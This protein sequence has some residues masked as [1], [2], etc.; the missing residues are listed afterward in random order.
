LDKPAITAYIATTPASLLR[1]VFV[2]GTPNEVVDQ[3][4][5]WRDHGLRYLVV[6]DRHRVTG[7]GRRFIQSRMD[8]HLAAVQTAVLSTGCC[9]MAIPAGAQGSSVPRIDKAHARAL[10]MS[11]VS[12]GEFGPSAR[13][14]AGDL[15]IADFHSLASSLAHR[16]ISLVSRVVETFTFDFAE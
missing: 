14:D 13:G 5:E 3:L 7:K 10:E 2:T 6:A 11:S 12:G 15:R 8:S 4:A 1:E 16:E 9:R